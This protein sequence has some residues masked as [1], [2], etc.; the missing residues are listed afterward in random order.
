MTLLAQLAVVLAKGPPAEEV[1]PGLL[2][3]LVIAALGVV[4]YLLWR[5]MNR[6]LRKVDF[7]DRPEDSDEERPQP[8]PTGQP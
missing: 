1:R 8:P 4:T 2:G 7:G 5:S 3:F 6:Q